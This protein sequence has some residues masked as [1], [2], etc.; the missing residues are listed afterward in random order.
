MSNRPSGSVPGSASKCSFLKKSDPCSKYLQKKLIYYLWVING[1]FGWKLGLATSQTLTVLTTYYNPARLKH[2]N[3][4]I[5][6]LL[7]CKFVER[8]II[9]NHNPALYI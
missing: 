8:V 5:R 6:N 3:H 1:Y 2:V 9:S 4:Q 7:K